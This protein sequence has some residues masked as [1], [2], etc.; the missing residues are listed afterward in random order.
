MSSSSDEL[1][2][3]E[4]ESDESLPSDDV[5][6]GLFGLSGALLTIGDLE[7]ERRNLAGDGVREPY[8]R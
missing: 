4:V 8:F 6:F 7:R 3:E 2:F 5:T 1:E